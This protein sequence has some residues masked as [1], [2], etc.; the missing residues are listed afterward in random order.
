MNV[1]ELFAG[2]GGLSLGLERAGIRVVGHV[3]IAVPFCQQVLHK[4]W[5]GVPDHDDVRTTVEWWRSDS[6]TVV[7]LVAGGANVIDALRPTWIIAEN[8][9]APRGRG[10]AAVLGDLTRFRYRARAAMVS[11]CAVGAP[12]A[13]ERL[14]TLAHPE[15]VGTCPWRALA[16]QAARADGPREDRPRPDGL[17]WWDAEPDVDRVA[18]AV[19]PGLDRRRALDNS[20]VPQVEHIGQLILGADRARENARVA[21]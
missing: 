4:H 21:A 10:L 11:A 9:P 13:P 15:G 16:A 7:D 2:I 6:R 14:F 3:E 19:P 1:L 5:P 18:Y 8:V 20:V 12:H 17:D